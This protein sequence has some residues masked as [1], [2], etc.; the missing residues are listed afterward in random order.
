MTYFS[1][2]HIYMCACQPPFGLFMTLWSSISLSL[3][4][5]R[6]S[7]LA[8]QWKVIGTEELELINAASN[9]RGVSASAAAQRPPPDGYDD[10]DGDADP[11]D[12]S[13]RSVLGEVDLVM[14]VVLSFCAIAL[15]AVAIVLLMLVYFDIEAHTEQYFRADYPFARY[16]PQVLYSAV[17]VLLS[18]VLEPVVAA[19]NE[20]EM[21]PTAAASEDALIVKQF[22][23]QFFNRSVM[24]VGWSD[25]LSQSRSCLQTMQCLLLQYM[26]SFSLICFS[27]PLLSSS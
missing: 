10:D 16:M 9:L 11:A 22:T 6:S 26:R 3:W 15:I 14:R 24:S 25:G 20:F 21:H 7:V 12:P 2:I 4:K 18:V 8:Y 13:G 17:P 19:L 5:R 1:S 27:S 23:V